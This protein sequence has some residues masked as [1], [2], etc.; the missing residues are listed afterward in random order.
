MRSC[1]ACGRLSNFPWDASRR[2]QLLRRSSH[3]KLLHP[4]SLTA[5]SERCCHSRAK[6]RTIGGELAKLGYPVNPNAMDGMRSGPDRR[7]RGRFNATR[8]IH[9]QPRAPQHNKTF[10]SNGPNV[11]VRGTAHQIFE[12]YVALAREATAS[13]DSVAAENYYQHAEHYFRAA[14]AGRDRDSLETPRPTAPAEI[15][16]RVPDTASSEIRTDAAQSCNDDDQS[17]L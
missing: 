17:G 7:P 13:G 11:R 3:N 10:D 16:T 15:E 6:E 5:N 2:R 12:R 1:S 9:P 8:P 14:N 4:N